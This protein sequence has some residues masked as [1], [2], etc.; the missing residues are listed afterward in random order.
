MHKITIIGAGSWGSALTR[1]I[2]DNALPVMV[3][4]ND[5]Q[6]IAEIK[7]YHT[8]ER[9]LPGEVLNRNVLATT[10]LA[11]AIAFG[12]IVLLVVPTAV[13][14]PVLEAIGTVLTTP[15]IFVNASKGLE[16]GTFKRMS[17]LI[18][19]VIPARY[20]TARVALT[21][22]SHAEE[23]IARQITTIVAACEDIKVAQ[24]IQRLFSNDSYFRIY[25][26][27]DLAGAELGGAL[28]NIYALASGMLAGSG[29]GVNPTAALVSR[30][31][32]EMKRLALA[33]G[34]EE[35]TLNG[36]AGVG[37]LMVTCF[38]PL[39]RNFQAG[40]KLAEGKDLE[41]SL[42]EIPMVV[43]GARTCKAAHDAAQALGVDVPIIDAVYQIIYEH[44]RPE[45]VLGAMMSRSLKDE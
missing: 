19:E 22:P 15:K 5:R 9:K 23:V 24:L 4:D 40:V 26:S 42:A 45:V 36:L 41:K 7:T 6:T 12:D 21:G 39:S 33:L 31:L 38:S 16:P 18:A 17:E 34:A 25:A 20:I 2:S 32:V 37:D 27:R 14:R 8:N 1:I 3:Y 11:E 30:A 13:M 35:E 43:E 28:K 10:D 29:Y 44:V